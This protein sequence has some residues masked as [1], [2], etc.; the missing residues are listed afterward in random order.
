MKQECATGSPSKG[1][2]IVGKPKPTIQIDYEPKY[3]LSS[4]ALFWERT[5][6]VVCGDLPRSCG[7]AETYV[8]RCLKDGQGVMLKAVL[9]DLLEDLLGKKEGKRDA[10][11]GSMSRRKG[12]LALEKGHFK[13]TRQCP[14][15]RGIIVLTG[16]MRNLNKGMRS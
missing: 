12:S 4:L 11:I 5:I 7:S 10:K 6:G 9:G 3:G 15:L 14:M 8:G 16:G 2:P 13:R 1:L